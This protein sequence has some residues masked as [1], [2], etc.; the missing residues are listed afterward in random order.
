MKKF[1]ALLLALIMCFSLVACGGDNA[2]DQSEGNNDKGGDTT[3]SVAVKEEKELVLCR[4]W[5]E[6]KSGY[7]IVL[8]EN[9]KYTSGENEYS[10]THNADKNTVSLNGTKYEIVQQYGVY[11]L[12]F[13]ND[14]FYVGAENYNA[15]RAIFIKDGREEIINSGAVIKVGDSKRLKCGAS[16]TLDKL[17]INEEKQSFLVY[18]TAKNGND[19]GCSEFGSMKANWVSLNLGCPFNSSTQNAFVD[20]QNPTR[21]ICISYKSLRL[22]PEEILSKSADSY[23]Y[24]KLTFKDFKEEFYIDINDFVGEK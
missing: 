21:E 9:G 13:N 15:V 1:I 17:E 20:A 7:S 8:K 12:V 11:M 16:F 3:Q 2:N 18:L 24:L 19:E 4:E 5:K 6:V 22:T 14:E 10:Y 23:G